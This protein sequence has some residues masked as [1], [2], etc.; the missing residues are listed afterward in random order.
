MA[1]EEILCWE[2]VG[3]NSSASMSYLVLVLEDLEYHPGKF[4]LDIVDKY[5]DF[6]FLKINTSVVCGFVGRA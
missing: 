5:I 6:E 4:K 3:A 1:G 2:T